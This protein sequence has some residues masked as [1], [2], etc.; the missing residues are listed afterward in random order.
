M[1]DLFSLASVC[2]F[3][4][5]MIAGNAEV[6]HLPEQIKKALWARQS[7]QTK[8]VKEEKMLRFIHIGCFWGGRE[9]FSEQFSVTM[10]ESGICNVRAD[11]KTGT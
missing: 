1:E 6:N 9:Y 8:D 11:N 10:P 5:S 2:L 7:D 4:R 3:D